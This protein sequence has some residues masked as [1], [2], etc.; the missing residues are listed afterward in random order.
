M[1]KIVA[2]GTAQATV[3]TNGG[4]TDAYVDIYHNLGYCPAALAFVTDTYD[5]VLSSLPKGD[6]TSGVSEWVGIFP[7]R[8]RL[9]LHCTWTGQTVTATFKYYILKEAS[10]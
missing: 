9:Y 2:T 3:V 8:I 7:D 4:V 6:R 1:F 5:N 10:I